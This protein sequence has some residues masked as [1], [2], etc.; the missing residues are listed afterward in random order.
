[1]DDLRYLVAIDVQPDSLRY[2]G[3]VELSARRLPPSLELDSVGHEIRQVM[4]GGRPLPY[5][6][7]PAEKRLVL[8]E[9]PEGTTSL[10][11]E[12]SGTIDDPGLRGFYVS[13]M[14]SGRIYTTYFEPTGARRLLPCLD[15][16]DAK[17]VFDVEITAAD[18]VSV[19]S[20]TTAVGTV[21]LGNGRRTV[22]FGPT[23]PMS[24]Y[25]LYIGIGPFEELEGTRNDPRVI[26]A[27]APGRSSVARFALE[28]G[29]R[30]VDYFAAYYRTPY[31]LPKLHLI[32]VPQFGTGAM[33][34][35]GAIAFQE[36]LLLHDE[37]ATVAS[38]MRSLEVICHE[39]AH[40]WFGNLVTMRWWNDLW[41][42]E[43]FASFV[44]VKASEALFPAWGA[45]DDFL[46]QQF[47]GAML[48]DALPHTHPIR[49]DVTD[50]DEIRQIFDAISYGKGASV[51][52]MAEAYVGEE[53]FR[54]GVSRYLADHRFGNAESG[55]LWKAVAAASEGA[56]E[57][58]FTEWVDRPGFPVVRARREGETLHLEQRRFTLAG[59]VPA[60]P[61]PIPLQVRV[62]PEVHRRIFDTERTS[63]EHVRG[64]PVVNPGRSGF[65]RVQYEGKLREEL[66]GA[67]AQLP[68]VDRWGL[69]NDSRAIFL[70]GGIDLAEY[71]D[72]LRLLEAETDA[73]VVHELLDLFQ[74][75]FPL[76]HRIPRW[77]AAFRSIVAAQ[78]DRLGLEPV[79][80]EPDRDR[81]LREGLTLIRARLE[82]PF[83]ASLAKM[84]PRLDT[85]S[86]ELARPVLTAY[87]ITAGPPEHDALR[88]RLAGAS[89]VDVQRST[90]SALGALGRDEWVREGLEMGLTGQ[91]LLGVW[92]ELLGSALVANPDRAGAVWSFLTER[93]DVFLKFSAGTGTQGILLQNALP[94]LGLA[95]PAEVR[96]W[97]TRVTFPESARGVANGLDLL[98]V[99]LRVLERSR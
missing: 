33:E 44:A 32:A 98:E 16:P 2:T 28:Q 3:R 23:P 75:M 60:A 82:P 24:T 90:A 80:R 68:P 99:Y 94:R 67:F 47:A 5:R 79:E 86:P 54:R 21:R 37:H 64:V 17:A 42:N 62:G 26:V 88:A 93:I 27:T 65:Y 31:P 39:V 25:L 87:A 49:V 85:L 15:R 20:N 92:L 36:Y 45:W 6:H 72:V 76:V 50:P 46:G 91:L 73:F 29:E 19:I 13:P 78:S 41:L 8:P 35:W 1:M 10:T 89:S 18:G 48:W 97:A 84:Y 56:V 7:E 57:R 9:I 69:V 12:Y 95:R 4:A 77:E 70:S 30:A 81:R 66:L 58:V 53:A 22:R 11:I 55:D 74:I 38:K 96:E 43:S 14:G 63:L 34:N 83:A 71:L 52:R 61:W 59:D 51:L 40:Q